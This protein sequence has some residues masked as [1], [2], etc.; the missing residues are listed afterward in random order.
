[1]KRKGHAGEWSETREQHA[2]SKGLGATADTR[3]CQ[4]PAT[5]SAASANRRSRRVTESVW[6]ILKRVQDAAAGENHAAVQ[7]EEEYAAFHPC[8]QPPSIAAQGTSPPQ[9][10]HNSALD[11]TTASI[12]Q[13]KQ[14]CHHRADNT[15]L[16]GPDKDRRR[17]EFYSS[18]KTKELII[19]S[20]SQWTYIQ[21]QERKR[22]S[23]YR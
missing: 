10:P 19:Y 23:Q 9:L 12:Q 16:K 14:K 2:S 11:H 5:E 1:M 4:G 21:G 18:W 6:Q 8:P 17:L 3:V 7:D 13:G 20:G 15:R 22:L